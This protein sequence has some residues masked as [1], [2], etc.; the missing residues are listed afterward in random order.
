VTAL[1]LYHPK[2]DHGGLVEDF[3]RDYK[4][5]KNKELKLLSLETV[6]GAEMAQL[7]DITAYPAVLVK[8]NDGSLLKLWQGG[9][10]ATSEL[11]SYFH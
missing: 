8:A 11:D 9:L 5:A 10:P 3:A 4:N 6:E 2:S 1:I 7:Y